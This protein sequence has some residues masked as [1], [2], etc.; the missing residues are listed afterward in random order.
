MYNKKLLLT[1]LKNLNQTKAPVKKKDIEENPLGKLKKGG[2]KKFSS[3]LG[4]KN[5]LYTKNSLY[6]KPKKNPLYKKP[7]Y[8]NKIYDPYGMAFDNGGIIENNPG[9]PPEEFYKYWFQNRVMPTAEGQ[10]LLD[11]VRPEA[12]ERA[13]QSVPYI[14]SEKLNP[15]EAGYYD[16]ETQQIFLN[17]FLPEA[18]IEATKHHEF[19]HHVQGDKFYDVLGKPHQYLIEQN[20]VGPKEIDTGNPEWDK[21]L[22]KNYDDVTAHEELWDRVMTLRRKAGF[23]PNQVITVKDVEDYFKRKKEAGEALDPDIEDLKGV[24]KGNQSIV[25]LLNDMVSVPGQTEDIPYLQ[26]GGPKE[27]CPE[28]YIWNGTECILNPFENDEDLPQNVGIAYLPEDGRSYYDP[29]SDT[30]N[31]NPN[32]S[33]AEL[34]HELVHAWQNRTG[35]LRTNPNLPQQRPP[36]VASDEQA[37]SYYTRKGDEVDQYLSDLKNIHPE[38]TG[39]I[40]TEDLNRFIP[41]QIKYDKVIDPLMYLDPTTMEGEAEYLSQTRG[42]PGGIG[43]RKQGGVIE[44]DLTEKEIQKYVD[45]GYIIEDISVPTLTRMDE[46]GEKRKKRRD[47]EKNVEVIDS[48]EQPITP[49]NIEQV[50]EKPEVEVN[51]AQ[52]RVPLMMQFSNEFQ[53]NNPYNAYYEKAAYDYLKSKK[54]WNE[55]LGINKSNLPENV[56]KRIQNNYYKD[57]EKYVINKSKSIQK[58][59]MGKFDKKGNWKPLMGKN[60]TLNPLSKRPTGHGSWDNYGDGSIQPVYPEQF[61]MGPG[62][63]M[64][65]FAGR[66]AAKGIA[67]LANYA[68]IASAPFLTPGNALNAYFAY[69][70]VKP[71]GNISKSIDAFSEGDVKEGAL[72][73]GMGTLGLLPFVKP[74]VQGAR[75]LNQL[76]TPGSIQVLPKSGNYSF[77]YKSPAEGGL[78]VGNPNLNGSE[79]VFK[80][81]TEAFNKFSRYADDIG[82]GSL[83]EFKIMK[84]TPSGLGSS[85]NLVEGMTLGEMSTVGQTIKST[86]PAL[87]SEANEVVDLHR[88]Q[89]IEEIASGRNIAPLDNQTVLQKYTSDPNMQS[90]AS[91][92]DLGISA[93]LRD[94]N[95]E[96]EYVL[97]NQIELQ[98]RF[99][100]GVINFDEYVKTNDELT[101]QLKTIDEKLNTQKI[102]N[103]KALSDNEVT[104]NIIDD[105][106]QNKME[107]WQTD[108][109]QRRLQT[110]IDNTPSL[111][112]QTPD[113]LI[114]GIGSMNNINRFY[115]T[116][117]VK[118]NELLNEMSMYD[119]MYENGQISKSEYFDVQ[120]ELDEKLT[121]VDNNI[122]ELGDNIKHNA[123]YGSV[124]NEL[125]I[126][127]GKFSTGELPKVTAHE[128]GHFLGSYAGRKSGTTYLDETLKELDLVKSESKQLE[129]PGLDVAEESKAHNLFGNAKPNYISETLKYFDKGSEGTE[130]VPFLAEVRQDLIDKGL[131]KSEYDPITPGL[132]KKHFDQYKGMRGEKYP[133][134]IYDIIKDKPKNFNIMSKVLNNLPM[135]IGAGLMIDG[136]TNDNNNSNLEQ[137]GLG[138][139]GALL[140]KNPGLV[141]NLP[142]AL[143]E[144]SM[145]SVLANEIAKAELIIPKVTSPLNLSKIDPIARSTVGKKSDILSSLGPEKYNEFLKYLYSQNRQA[146]DSP[147]I[148]FKSSKPTSYF[149]KDLRL[150]TQDDVRA[151]LFK[152]KYCLEGSECAKTSNAVTNR[153]FTD[154]TGKEFEAE[155]NA[156]NAWHLEDQMTR[157][158][159]MNISPLLKQYGTELL[160]V[161]DRVLMGNQG[162]QSTQVAGYIA[163]PSVRHAGFFAGYYPTQYGDIPMLFESGSGNPMFMNPI[164]NTFTGPNSV[165]QVIRPRQFLDDEFGLSLVDKNIRYAYRD[166]PSVAIYSSDVPEVQK[167]IEDAEPVR[168]IVKKEYDITNDEFDE[169]LVSLIGIGAQETKLGAK[170]PGSKMSKIKIK[171][172]DLLETVGLTQPIKRTLNTYK[173][174]VNKATSKASDLPPYPGTSYIEMESAKLAAESNMPFDEA[175]KIVKSKYKPKPKKIISTVEPSKG[176]FR[177]KYQTKTADLAGFHRIKQEEVANGMAQMAENYNKIKKAYPD[178]DPRKIIDLTVLMWNSPGKA[179]NKE[180]VE[181]YLF[182][183]GNPDPNAFKFD[184]IDKVKKF[185]DDLIN[186]KPQSTEDFFEIVRKSRPEIQYKEGGQTSN[187]ND[188]LEIEIDE[189]SIGQL[190]DEGY[191]VQEL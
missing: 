51:P 119:K 99:E 48:T 107:L 89:P 97:G 189:N 21:N 106:R 122:S 186:V 118:R 120:V 133:L 125:G 100:D 26:F 94:L 33:D 157:H 146:Y 187:D 73:A 90:I 160:K 131:I 154:I 135:V 140:L 145:A 188:Y 108:E 173:R 115:D 96:K 159:G 164:S 176:I 6:K 191:I 30:I 36:I 41:D 10:K 11:K 76:K 8:K 86:T 148:E 129:I 103:V 50:I 35:R 14:Y 84:Q 144:K 98:K 143:Q 46:G 169:L 149:S 28:G 130:R 27:N 153:V 166:K 155:Q 123:F 183:K 52:E 31:L 185:R 80:G 4:A 156:H 95:A 63:G 174:V 59:Y 75:I 37:A 81:V 141:K 24:T 65:G 55:A 3:N 62:A 121:I 112:E 126:S 57:L 83:G 93:P 175:L 22:K 132:L 20:I 152:E 45:G 184:Y 117:L 178:A 38:M 128:L 150:P 60:N 104:A 171:T 179:Q 9:G 53:E 34:N 15:D 167:L 70:A 43:F 74:T 116:Q 25:N 102:D 1:A 127:P 42:R 82:A 7:N 177:Q 44:L 170:L 2:T 113:S 40:W 181:F 61:F 32:A 47:K 54:G 110:M 79:Q 163:D 66:A 23:E 168:D 111:K 124:N 142:K 29:L 180:L 17:K 77:L 72:Q 138:L 71:D 139:F 161:G 147:L 101:G 69:E 165:R 88:V 68:P 190:V 92:D 172:Q 182:G 19:G 91:P 134:R 58:D 78:L 13:S 64:L 136:L 16:P 85:T 162:N 114:E 109:G 39:N 5:V 49:E 56:A 87:A 12:L 105:M 158:G 18:Q 67:K 151:F 137:A